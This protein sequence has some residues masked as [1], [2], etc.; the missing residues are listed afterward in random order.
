M[1]FEEAKTLLSGAVK[2][3]LRDHAFGDCEVLWYVEDKNSDVEGAL[4]EI[5]SGYFG[6]GEALV[7]VEIPHEGRGSF[8]GEEAYE[9]RKCF[10]K[11]MVERNDETGPDEFVVGQV[12]PGLTLE[13]VR[14]ELE[15]E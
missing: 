15:G 4:T 13:G 3:E 5:A 12:M 14:R 6:S 2:S 9:L 10:A 7:S 8:K 11:E 1:N